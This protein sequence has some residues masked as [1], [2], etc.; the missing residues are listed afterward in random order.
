MGA[1]KGRFQSLR[2][3]RVNIN[4]NSDHIK[5]CR[6]VTVAII[7]HNMV[8]DVDGET[9]G[10]AFMHVHTAQEEEEDRGPRDV[11]QDADEGDG[12]AKH[13]RLRDELLAHIA[14]R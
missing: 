11:Q 7:L 10:A 8:I 6:W 4:S 5:A 1:L 13:I 12:Q 3:L 2:G 9:S 14:G